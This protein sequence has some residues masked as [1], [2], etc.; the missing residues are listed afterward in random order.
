MQSANAQFVKRSRQFWQR[1]T[2]TTV[3]DADVRQ[4]MSNVAGYMQILAEWS[5]AARSVSTSDA[6]YAD[7]AAPRHHPP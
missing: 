3:S 4:I 5:E 7:K 2:G 6:E 1:K